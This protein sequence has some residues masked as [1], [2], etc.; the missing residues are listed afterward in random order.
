MRVIAYCT[1][2]QPFRKEDETILIFTLLLLEVNYHFLTSGWGLTQGGR[3]AN[4][5]Q[6]AELPIGQEED[7]REIFPNLHH[8]ETMICAGGKGKGGCQGDSGGP[9]A[10][11]ED[12]QWIL[13]GVVSFGRADCSP[14]HYTVFAR[15]S[16]LVG[17][18]KNMIKTRGQ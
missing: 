3:K 6:E 10:C 12:R 17:W 11:L 15:V 16:S 13:R 1:Y 18:I 4:T 9:L 2:P 8:S 7:C 14:N 5:L